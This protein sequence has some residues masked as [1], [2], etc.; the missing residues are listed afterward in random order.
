MLF[1]ED[2]FSDW[3]QLERKAQELLEFKEVAD[4]FKDIVQTPQI[5]IPTEEQRAIEPFETYFS[6]KLNSLKDEI[7]QISTEITT[8]HDFTH[9]FLYEIDYQIREAAFSLSEFKFWGVGYNNGVD[10]KRNHLERML[11]DLRKERRSTELRCWEDIISLRKDL[12][13]ALSEYKDII[14][15]G[16]I[17]Q[18]AGDTN[19]NR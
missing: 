6:E 12:R 9:K 16:N 19:G 15:R 4:L 11:S 2:D 13:E 5:G 18:K 3:Y 14:R 7:Q 17:L 8:R 1:G 10:K